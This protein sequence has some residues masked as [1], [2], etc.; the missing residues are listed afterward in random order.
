MGSRR[1]LLYFS[2]SRPAE[3]SAPIAAIEDRFP[4]LFE[5]RRL[6]YPKY[7]HLSEEQQVDQGIGGF[8]NY[9][10]KPN[11]QLFAQLAEEITGNPVAQIE[12]IGGRRR[13]DPA[14]S[15]AR[16]QG[17]RR[18]DQFRFVADRADAE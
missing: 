7:E 5:L 4:A 15:G 18:R 11:F 12:R 1:V 8:L 17:H 2:W 3:I 14:D 6:Y 10:Q 16:G 9:I 13:D